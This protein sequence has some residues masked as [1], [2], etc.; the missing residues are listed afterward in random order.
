M[1]SLKKYNDLPENFNRLSQ[2]V[3]DC[4][5]QVH[6]HLGAGYLERIY[7]DCLCMEMLERGIAFER[8]FPMKLVYKGRQ[9]ATDFRLDL[10]VENKILLE[11]K[12]VDK[13][14]PLHDAQIYSYLKMSG[15]SLGLLVN[16]N[17]PLIK[18]G[19]KRFVPQNL[20]N[21]V[22]PLKNSDGA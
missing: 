14:L 22:T 16:F 15:L 19:I 3:V 7:E 20:R 10:V 9:I 12:S 6:S 2:D 5:F 13:I 4:I 11:L 21:S 8:Q 18:D 17:V 1:S